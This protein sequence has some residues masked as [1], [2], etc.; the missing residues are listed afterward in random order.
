[1]ESEPGLLDREV[2]PPTITAAISPTFS[3]QQQQRQQHHESYQQQQQQQ[4][5]QLQ[6][7]HHLHQQYL[8]HE[9]PVRSPSFQGSTP[10]TP[11]Q[12]QYQQTYA[13]DSL[14]RTTGC[15]FNQ[16]HDAK[17]AG[18]AIPG[19]GS[20]TRPGSLDRPRSA[21]LTPEELHSMRKGV[22]YNLASSL[23]FKVKTR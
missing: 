7:Q 8:Q 5:K 6:Q 2:R 11:R 3:V 12:Q 1:M 21:M 22:K 15:T 20:A 19:V 16:L 13:V 14:E 10:F 23:G 17:E 9:Q 18:Q 4:Q